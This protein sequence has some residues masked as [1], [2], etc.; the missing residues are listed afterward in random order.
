M[1]KPDLTLLNYSTGDENL[2]MVP[3]GSCVTQQT[4]HLPFDSASPYTPES[5]RRSG[6]NR[7][8]SLTAI[9]KHIL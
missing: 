5:T 9:I 3:L 1:H 6:V 4:L 2:R 8:D 7:I